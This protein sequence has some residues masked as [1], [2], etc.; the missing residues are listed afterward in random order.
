M[1]VELFSA[2]GDTSTPTGGLVLLGVLG[3][4]AT[5]GGGAAAFNIRGTADAL[6]RMRQAQLEHKARAAMSLTMV[7]QHQQ[8]AWWFRMLG[9]LVL[10]TGVLLL[11]LDAVILAVE[12]G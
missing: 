8:P 4:L 10:S 3:L 11:L 7:E 6:N 5:L 2:A 9:A 1:S 12:H